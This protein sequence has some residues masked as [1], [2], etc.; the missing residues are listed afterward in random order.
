[1][2][3]VGQCYDCQYHYLSRNVTGVSITNK[4][5]MNMHTSWNKGLILT[6]LILGSIYT[7]QAQQKKIT[8]DNDT[9]GLKS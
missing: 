6:I 5:M 7:I 2:V 4:K 8:I 1:M 3:V 9:L